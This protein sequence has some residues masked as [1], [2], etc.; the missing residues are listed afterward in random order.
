[1]EVEKWFGRHNKCSE[2][3]RK[4]GRKEKSQNWKCQNQRLA[5]P[6]L[7]AEPLRPNGGR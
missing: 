4:C 1:V 2:G 7:E 5:Y 6:P 3:K